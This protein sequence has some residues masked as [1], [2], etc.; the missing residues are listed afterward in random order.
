MFLARPRLALTLLAVLALALLAF[1]LRYASYDT[2]PDTVVDPSTQAFQ[3]E[4]DYESVFGADPLVVLVSGNVENLINSSALTSEIGIEGQLAR[5]ADLGVQSVYGPSSIATVAGATIQNVAAGQITTV[6][7]AAQTKAFSDAKAAVK[8]DAEGPTMA[9]N[10]PRAAGTAYINNALNKFPEL[11]KL[12]PLQASNPRWMAAL[13]INPDNGKPKPR[14]ASVIP[15]PNHIV[16]TARLGTAF[17]PGSAQA[18]IDLI[19]QQVAGTP[20][21]RAVTITGVPVL[22]AAIERGLRL[23]LVAGMILGI[24]SMGVLLLVALRRRG[25]L[26]LRILPLVAGGAT[27]LVLAGR[28]AA[29]GYRAA[30]LRSRTGIEAASLQSFLATFTLALNPATLAAF[31]I[32]LGLAVDYA[33]QFLY[34]YTQALESGAE[35]PWDLARRGA[36]IATWRAAMCTVGGL[37]A[38]LISTIPMVRQFG[39]VMS[40]GVV[41]A[42]TVARLTVLAAVRAWPNI[43]LPPGVRPEPEAVPAA[44]TAVTPGPLSAPTAAASIAAA[45]VEADED[46][47]D[48][49]FGLGLGTTAATLPA[50][51]EVEI[52]E[53]T[54]LMGSAQAVGEDSEE[55][56]V[57]EPTPWDPGP[58]ALPELG[59]LVA[60]SR[61]VLEPAP[62]EEERVTVPYNTP[63]REVIEVLPAEEDGSAGRSETVA[64]DAEPQAVAE[65]PVAAAIALGGDEDT[66]EPGRVPSVLVR[67]ALRRAPLILVPALLLAMVGW[68]ALPFSTYESDPQKLVSPNLPALQDLNVVRAATGSAGELD[69]I[70]TG[71]DV[72]SAAA[73]DWTRNLPAVAPRHRKHRPKPPRH[74]THPITPPTPSTP[75]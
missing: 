25:R 41:I 56:P 13:F 58:E 37:L 19:D 36:G 22:E 63:A 61:A 54:T 52:E 51:V 2:A 6:M 67:F 57:W 66:N 34:R 70:L 39:V 1:A 53:A 59:P 62:V 42:W 71:P 68:A 24:A 46:L 17:R 14:F 64:R 20:L 69:F 9:N 65:L 60:W 75:P 31:P 21:A 33:V 74:P 40:L 44:A 73:L 7:S 48:M 18:L 11:Q 16:V 4:V 32:A 55:S 43:G 45:T 29:V 38:L 10:A 47:D 26:G 15:D 12:A 28:V 35:V 3:H 30:Y 72:T 23:S 27:V 5:H 8:G 49:L 50:V